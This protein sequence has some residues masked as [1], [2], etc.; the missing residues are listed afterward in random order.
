[1]ESILVHAHNHGGSTL[2][3]LGAVGT[4]CSVCDLKYYWCTIHWD[5]DWL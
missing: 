1:M 3:H 5:L 2:R 4:I